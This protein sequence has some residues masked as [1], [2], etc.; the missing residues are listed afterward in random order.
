MA[1]LTLRF[2]FTSQGRTAMMSADG[3][4]VHYFDFDI[5]EQET[6][7]PC[8]F[9]SDGRRVLFLS[10]E[11]RRDG[12]GKPFAEYYHKTPTHIWVYDLEKYALTEVATQQ[13]R[14]VFE[15]PQLLIGDERILLQVVRDEGG[16]IYSTNLDGTD[17]RE[18]TRLSEGLPYGFALSP[19]KQRLAYHLASPSGYQIWTSNVEGGERTLV[20]ADADSLYFGPQWS[21][22]GEWLA[23][24][25]CRYAEDPGH[26]W[27]DGYIARPDGS[28]LR[29][30]TE[31]QAL[32]FAATYGPRAR[33]GGGSNMVAWTHDGALLVPRRSPA[34]KVAWEFQ[35]QRPDTDHF[36]RDFNPEQACGGTQIDRIDI[37]TGASEPLTPS[38]EGVWNFRQ[39][40][41]PDGTQL[42]FCRATTGDSPSIWVADADGRN[43]RALT[44]GLDEMGADHPRWLPQ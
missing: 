15:T 4:G 26:D 42:L 18:V 29:M 12:P 30:L 35:S 1:A 44:K 33:H 20:A 6:W 31:G 9:F 11:A 32:W 14:A 19:D 10:M 28:E 17:A 5:P 16:Q 21:P 36:N 22:D 2:F 27:G 39:S 37:A 24:M 34:A 43:A 7:Q 23:F 8:G 41:S 13:R 25:G 3:N 40:Q 38:E